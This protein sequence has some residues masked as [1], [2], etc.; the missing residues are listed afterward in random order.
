MT[1]HLKHLIREKKT[2]WYK[3]RNSGFN[4][5]DLVEKYKALNKQVKNE[6]KQAIRKFERELALKSKSNQKLVYGYV[7]SKT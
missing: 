3:C 2:T 4:S 5:P 7:N 1:K 6:V